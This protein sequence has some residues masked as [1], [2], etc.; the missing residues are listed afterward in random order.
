MDIFRELGP[1]FVLESLTK[2]MKSP[3]TICIGLLIRKY[4]KKKWSHKKQE[5]KG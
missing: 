2:W 3:S 4:M 5:E 1:T